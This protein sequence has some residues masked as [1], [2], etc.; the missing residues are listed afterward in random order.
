MKYKGLEHRTEV[1]NATKKDFT[2]AESN[3]SG[4]H[5]SFVATIMR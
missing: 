1:Y 2:D 3:H 5:L 4:S